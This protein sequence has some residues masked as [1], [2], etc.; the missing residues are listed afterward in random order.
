MLSVLPSPLSKEKTIITT[1]ETVGL[2]EWIIDGT[3]LVFSYILQVSKP[4]EFD[5]F[6]SDS[7]SG[8]D[9]SDSDFEDPDELEVPG[10][11]KNLQTL[12]NLNGDDAGGSRGG[13]SAGSGAAAA[14][15][16]PTTSKALISGK[17]FT[18]GNQLIGGRSE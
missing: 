18:K 14:A 7:P 13:K 1:G 5:E 15:G 8:A 17:N 4:T 2:A 9:D 16:R 3:C 11:G 6:D 12:Q 10:G